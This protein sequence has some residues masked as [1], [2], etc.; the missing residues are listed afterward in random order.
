VKER[1]KHPDLDTWLSECRTHYGETGGR[2]WEEVEPVYRVGWDLAGRDRTRGWREVE[3]EYR[4]AWTER[5]PDKPWDR[6][7]DAAQDA[8]DRLTAEPGAS[9]KAGSPLAHD[10]SSGR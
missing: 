10:E 8:W 4:K 1:T 6:F 9:P 7:L 2:S 3:P 5:Y